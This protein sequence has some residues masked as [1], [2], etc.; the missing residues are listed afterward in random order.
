M[1]IFTNLLNNFSQ[2]IQSLNEESIHR[3]Y[4]SV[5]IQT[6][7]E[8]II[9][10]NSKYKLIQFNLNTNHTYKIDNWIKNRP[11]DKTRVNEIY[12]YYKDEEIDLIPG[13]T[14]VWYHLKKLYI[15]DGLH[16]FLAAQKLV[17]ND[18]KDIKI[19][20]HINLSKNEEDIIEEFIKIN[21]SIPIPS[22]YLD[23]E[24]LIKKQICQNIAEEFCKQY[25][26]FISTSRKPHIYN[27]NRDLLIEW[28]STFKID[29]HIKN[30][31]KIIFKILLKLNEKAKQQIISGNIQHPKKCDKYNFYIFFLEKEY[32]KSE[33]ENNIKRLF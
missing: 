33:I 27:F 12:Q 22:I 20:L 32:I 5:G 3:T 1:D 25:P 10:Q 29:F 13:I 21:K 4:N 11:A 17:K 14:Y 9:S 24:L 8:L 23:N 7:N 19:L 28:F 26:D 15:Y 6:N 2:D 30:L 18:N 31:D 16:R